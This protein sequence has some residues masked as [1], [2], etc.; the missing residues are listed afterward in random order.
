MWPKNEKEKIKLNQFT[1]IPTGNE[2][3]SL[4]SNNRKNNILIKSH[5]SKGP[6][7]T[8]PPPFLSP[9]PPIF[10]IHPLLFLFLL[11]HLSSF[12]SS[13]FYFFLLFFLF[14]LLFFFFLPPLLIAIVFTLFLVL[15]CLSLSLEE[16]RCFAHECKEWGGPELRAE[17]P[18]RFAALLKP[19]LGLLGSCGIKPNPLGLHLV[20]SSPCMS[21]HN[22]CTP[23]SMPPTSLRLCL[24]TLKTTSAWSTVFLS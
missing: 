5:R 22:S 16:W 2:W 15:R 12:S 8:L 10:P 7:P 20:S 21:S 14:F 11:P 6:P 3:G 1:F 13:S 23:L 4:L 19:W 9:L 17:I 18:T 24:T